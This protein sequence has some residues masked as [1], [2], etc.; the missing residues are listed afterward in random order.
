LFSIQRPVEFGTVIR[1]FD[2]IAAKAKT[3]SELPSQMLA[4]YPERVN[5][6]VL[7][8]LARAMKSST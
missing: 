5:S 7:W 3:A 8:I 6:A 1:Y 2:R 4:I